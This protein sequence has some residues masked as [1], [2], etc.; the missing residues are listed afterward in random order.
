MI[1]D[2]I[3]I[4][5]GPAG[6]TAAIKAKETCEK[7]KILIIDRNK[8]LG[9]K[10][11]ATGNGRCNIANSALDL[12][13][14]HS[15]NEFFPYQ[16]I[17]TE[18][19]KKLKEFFMD[20]GVAIYD[21]GG[22]L[23]PQSMQASTV[24]WALSDRIKHLGI[25]IH[26]TEEAESVEPTDEMYGVV[27][28]CAEYTAR[29]VVA[30]PG[31]AAAPK[32]GG[33]ESVYRLLENTDIRTIAP[34]PALCRLKTHEDI[35]DLVGVRARC[36]V[37]LLCDGD[38]YDSESGEIQF[39]DGWLSGIAVFNLSMQCIDLLNDGRTPVVEVTLVPE[40]DEDDVLGYLRKF[41]DSNPDRRLEAMSNGLVNEKIARFI[42][43]R[44]ELKSVTAARLTDEELDRMVFEIKH[45]RFEISG[46]GGYDESQ[47]ACGGIDTRQL[48][49]DSMEAD[50]YKGL[51]VAG[52]YADVTGK[53]GGYNIMWA[54]MTGMRAGE[55]AGKRLTHDKNK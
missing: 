15:C 8:K 2:T 22:Y 39:A 36:R 47:A 11:Y 7:A 26:T 50:G 40:M 5:G 9:K 28:D 30:A 51:Y 12:S 42:I 33:T 4:G 27:T 1:Y 43:N 18:S 20:L 29:T 46:H 24:V 44:L 21:D 55:A 53:C 41:R 23:Y 32:L 6:M 31:S 34:H 48:R 16:I 25:E 35:S 17:N 3:V 54:V 38:V 10:L 19:Y 13:S 14:Y 37:S 49:P 45:M 52:E